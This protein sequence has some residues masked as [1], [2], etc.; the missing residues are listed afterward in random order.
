MNSNVFLSRGG[1]V[2]KMRGKINKGIFIRI[3]LKA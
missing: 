2:A 1:E 3:S